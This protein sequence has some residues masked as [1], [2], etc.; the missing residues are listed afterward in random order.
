MA[1]V[2]F[3]VLPQD[4]AGLLPFRSPMSYML[5]IFLGQVFGPSL[6]A[7]VMTGV[8]EG[9]EGLRRFI[10]RIVQWRVGIQW[11]L[12]VLIGIPVIMSLGTVVLPGIW[13]SFKPFENPVSGLLSYLVFYVYPALLIG[14]PLFEKPGWRGFALPRLQRRFGPMAASLMLGVLWAF[15]HAPIWLSR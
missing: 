11:Y 6:A 4:G 1:R 3:F 7:F 9:K 10:E 15:W 13:Q 14:G 2:V 8:T 5:T 12:F